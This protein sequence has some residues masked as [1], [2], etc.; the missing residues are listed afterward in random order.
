MKNS[1]VKFLYNGVSALL[2]YCNEEK[3]KNVV[4]TTRLNQNLNKLKEA[5]D[6]IDKCVNQDLI[7][8]EKKAMNMLKEQDPDSND[9]MKA[10]SLLSEEEVVKHNELMKEYNEDMDKDYDLVLN[11][12]DISVIENTS[13][14]PAFSSILALLIKE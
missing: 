2:N 1:K 8:L 5:S 3:I 7:E 6:I 13:I 10:M 4:L 12:M 9:F 14:D 11:L